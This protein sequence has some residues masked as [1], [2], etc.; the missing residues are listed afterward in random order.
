MN[1]SG[2]FW[3]LW[4]SCEACIDQLG[5][6]GTKRRDY[7][8]QDARVDASFGNGG[9]EQDV[10]CGVRLVGGDVIIFDFSGCE[11]EDERWGSDGG[12]MRE[13]W[14]EVGGKK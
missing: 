4:G 12:G 14:E 8:K 7:G 9:R 6:V 5:L 10:R 2:P 1:E 3:G 11:G 13:G